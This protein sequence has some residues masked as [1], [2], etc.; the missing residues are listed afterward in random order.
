MSNYLCCSLRTMGTLERA[1]LGMKAVFEYIEHL[2]TS[3]YPDTFVIIWFDVTVEITIQLRHLYIV[4]SQ[5][6]QLLMEKN[7]TE[8][9]IFLLPANFT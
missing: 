1:N 8:A 6:G 2:N 3:V 5:T 4:N 9:I 7:N